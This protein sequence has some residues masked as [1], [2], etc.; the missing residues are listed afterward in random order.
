MH[1]TAGAEKAMGGA[2]DGKLPAATDGTGATPD[3]ADGT[4]TSPPQSPPRRGRR[5]IDWLGSFSAPGLVGAVVFFC[6]SQTPSLIPRT[7][8][9]QALASGLSAIS[10][11]AVMVIVAWVLR[12]FGISPE[13][14][15][16]VRSIGWIV[17]GAAAAIA[18]VTFMILGAR[19]QDDLRALFGLEPEPV[20]YVT[21]FFAAAAVFL[22]VLLV[23]RAFRWVT[24]RLRNLLD[25][26]L[27]FRVAELLA[28]VVVTVGAILLLNDAV[29]A[30]LMAWLNDVYA[31]AD[32][33][34]KPDVEQPAATE[35]SGSPDSPSTWDSLGREGRAFVAGGPTIGELAAFSAER[36]RGAD[37]TQ[38][39]RVYAGLRSGETLDDVA[40]VVVEE[41]DRTD[42][43]DRD[44]L[45]VATATGT[46]SIPPSMADAL[47]YMHG[48]DTAIASMQYSYLPSWVSFVSDR[49]TPPA[50]GKALFEAVYARWS[51]LPAD[52]R[53]ALMVFGESLGSY[54]SQGTFS[55]LQ[56]IAERTDG[57]MWFGTP[58]FTSNWR[59]LTDQRDP[60]SYEY[61]PVYDAGRTVRW[62]DGF[63][64]SAAE[65]WDIE[66][67]WEEPRVVYVQHPSDAV[68][69]WSPDLILNEPD[70][71]TEPRGPG[72]LPRMSWLPIITF[73]HVSFD[74]AVAGAAPAG[75]GHNYQTEYVDGWSA[76]NPPDG[77]TDADSDALRDLMA[78]RAPE[79]LLAP[80]AGV[81]PFLPAGNT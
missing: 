62:S 78:E 36:G 24:R 45:V 80:P 10:A 40:N 74:Q 18:I 13:W 65:L 52:D 57:A 81:A 43:W 32:R 11:Y 46:G 15:R 7:W 75:Y 2:V 70:W 63:Q 39:I 26:A 17:F 5:L 4:D 8:L 33:G 77:W 14:S 66:T 38:P 48:G 30:N 71:L 76:L 6:L 60:G 35:R 67:T 27:P 16:R 51:G 37:V 59:Y 44:V 73:L 42:A 20:P 28:V 9:F 61:Q 58:N 50:A 68:V 72:V 79:N 3:A 22:L 53:P 29:V 19:W 34:D 23:A 21:V 64:G 56:D 54:G 12:R 55:G 47:E 1:A 49:D 41:L 25:K 69:W 31:T